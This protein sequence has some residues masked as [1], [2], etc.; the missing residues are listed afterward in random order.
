MKGH[1]MASLYF[2]IAAAAAFAVAGAA[3]AADPM[4]RK[5][6]EPATFHYCDADPDRDFVAKWDGN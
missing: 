6:G 4:S 5:K 1:S 3:F 2:R